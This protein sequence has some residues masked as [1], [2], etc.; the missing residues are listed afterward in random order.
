MAR[1]AGIDE[2]LFPLIFVSL[3]FWGKVLRAR[4]GAAD[5]KLFNI[6]ILVVFGGLVIAQNY[7]N[8]SSAS[9]TTVAVDVP[10]NARVL[11]LSYE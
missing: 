10:A 1:F 5:T 3:G 9:T 11:S 8:S 4:N 7:H 6:S 2:V